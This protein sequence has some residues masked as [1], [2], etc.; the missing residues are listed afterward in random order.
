M[1]F[2]FTKEPGKTLQKIEFDNKEKVLVSIVMP[3]YN[4][5]D[6]Y[7]RQTV[8]SVLNQTFPCFELLIIDDGSTDEECLKALDEV[9]KLD[10]RIKVFHK[11][12]EGLAATRDYG[13]AKSSEDSKY[14]FF[15]DSDDLIEPTYIECAYWT[16]ETNK[17]ATW[18]YTNSVGFDA[19]EYTWNVWFSSGK[20]KKQNDLVATSMIRKSDFWEVNGYELREKAINEDW[21]FWLKLIAKEKFPVRMSFYGFWYRRKNTG[22]LNKAAENKARSMQIIE[23]TAKNIKKEVEAIQYPYYSYD[24]EEITE[25]IENQ[26]KI[27]RNDN[28]KINILMI[29]PWMVMG[30][31]DKYNLDLVRG[32]DK[33]KFD[34]TIITT[35]PAKNIHRQKFEEF[36]TVY[37][38]TSFLDQRYW[39][40]FINYIIEKNN[41]SIIFNTNSETGYS[42]L[43]Y[44]KAKNPNV[45]IIDY[46]H[47]EEWYWRNGGYSRDSSSVAAVIDKTLTCNEGS[48]RVF[49]KDFKRKPE[50]IQT[51]YIGVDENKFNP[52]EYDKNEL[53]EK[54]NVHQKYAIGYICRITEQK[55]P[56]LLLQIIKKLKSQRDD[57]TVL[58]AGTGNLYN[59]I[60]NKANNLELGDSIKFIGNVEETQK[61]YVACDL[62]LNC[63]IKEGLA[64][65]S[66]ESLSMG[67]PVISSDVGGQKELINEDVGVIV[68]CMQDEN[69]IFKFEYSDDEIDSYVQAINKILED[70]DKY[71]SNCRKRILDGFTINH[72]IKNM[73]EIFENIIKNPNEEKLANGKILGKTVD[74]TK[75]LIVKH[76]VSNR[77]KYEWECAEHN[78]KHETTKNNYKFQLF[79]DRMWKHAWYRAFIRMLQK[80][81]IINK[82]KEIRK[83]EA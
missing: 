43:P 40:A 66:Y 80:T 67:V 28:G 24:W 20:M 35:E 15:L 5:K 39:L 46:V 79:K 33:D 60:R 63:S 75:E 78:K 4:E 53:R 25:K 73:T 22:E 21:N 7:L 3:C 54:Y 76:L 61:F 42:M 19:T 17:K 58:V 48:R 23:T 52:A 70:L 9:E 11:E 47:M 44:L 2:D 56:Y 68:P 65:T 49:I 36:A 14:L 26:P 45:P 38:L 64:L 57:F 81:K 30:G 12:N 83:V 16:L 72:M 77:I 32:L 41:I 82:I 74:I 1:E 8:N 29:I 18:A 59:K 10:N 6:I 71:K 55:R 31:A 62:T 27:K 37:D 51:V 13:A 50:E 69:D 34:I